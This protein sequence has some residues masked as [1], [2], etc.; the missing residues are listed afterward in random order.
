MPSSDQ[1]LEVSAQAKINLTLE[2]LGRRDDGYHQ[3]RTILQTVDLADRLTFG[4]SLDLEVECD[5]PEISGES[6]L[7]WTAATALADHCGISPR[8]RIVIKKGIPVSM[9]LGGGS[10]D[11][12]AAL[13]ALNEMWELGLSRED[14][15]GIAAGI[16]S[17]VAFF[18]TGGTALAEGRGELI[19]PLPALPPIP[20]T[21]ICPGVTLPRKTAVMYSSLHLGHYSDGGITTRMIQILVEG[22]FVSESVGGLTQNVFEQVV[23]Q[24][25]PELNGLSHRLKGMFQNPLRLAGSGPAMFSLPSDEYEFQMAA[26]ALQPQGVGVY[27]VHNTGPQTVI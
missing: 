13:I 5:Q 10:S 4:P 25:L 26:N 15:A 20:V 27:L 18:L 12:A 22:R 16:G 9:G 19:T 23:Y 14:L 3:V 1:I 7:V 6:N 24:V 2:V 17:D 21:L 8:A 11:A